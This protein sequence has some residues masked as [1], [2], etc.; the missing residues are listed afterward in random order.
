MS[1][2]AESNI[3]KL[4]G[5]KTRTKLLKLFLTNEKKSFY[6][7]EITR[8]I[9]EQVNSVRRELA[10]LYGL[11]VVKSDTYDNKLYYMINRNYAHF[12]ALK[13]I[14]IA[15]ESRAAQIKPATNSDKW[16][17]ATKPVRELL[18]LFLVADP[19]GAGSEVDML[20]VG[21][22]YD[23][24]LSKWASLIEKKHDQPLNYMILSAEDFYYRLSVKDRLITDV[25]ASGMKVIIDDSSILKKGE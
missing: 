10:N 19:L 3:D 5:S 20:V 14:F 22:D 17:M 8:L 16:E 23:G 15:D 9:D 2:K 25:V 21:N 13:S 24:Q 11:G 1:K 6:V 7:R 12:S 18:S 4:F